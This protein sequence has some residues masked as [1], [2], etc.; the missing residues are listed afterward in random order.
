MLTILCYEKTQ[1][2]FRDT[3]CISIT[4]DLSIAIDSVIEA[5]PETFS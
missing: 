4:I 5:Q 3:Y 1:A 2:V